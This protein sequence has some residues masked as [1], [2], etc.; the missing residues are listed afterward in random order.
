MKDESTTAESIRGLDQYLTFILHGEEY[1]INILKVRGIQGWEETT[2]IPG[3]PDYVVGLINLRGEVVPIIDLRTRFNL[4][5]MV[6]D[7][8]T[9]VIIVHVQQPGKER[10]VGIVVDAVSEV[11]N[12]NPADVRQPPEF[13][14]EINNEYLRGLVLIEEKM[15]ILLEIDR[16]IDWGL[17][18]GDAEEIPDEVEDVVPEVES[19]AL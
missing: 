16:L 6:Y 10:T 17:L 2:V 15:V 12:I 9:V 8:R 7:A 5:P 13:G 4:E 19:T 18:D 3:A 1:G 11:Y 14:K